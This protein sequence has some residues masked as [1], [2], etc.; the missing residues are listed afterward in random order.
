MTDVYNPEHYENLGRSVVAKAVLDFAPHRKCPVAPFEYIPDRKLASAFQ[1]VTR[2]LDA[3]EFLLERSDPIVTLWRVLSGLQLTPV[4]EALWR[5]RYADL[6]AFA[7]HV[8]V[9]LEQK[10]QAERDARARVMDT[11]LVKVEV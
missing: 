1:S 2:R 8:A 9:R 5:C 10:D 7:A 3:G 4:T 11:W 6:K